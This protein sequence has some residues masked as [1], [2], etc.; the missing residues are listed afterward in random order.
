MAQ[1]DNMAEADIIRGVVKPGTSITK[2][3][4]VTDCPFCRMLQ[5]R[6][7]LTT[8]TFSITWPS[9]GVQ[10]YI[11]TTGPPIFARVRR[12]SPKK[13]AIAKQE[14]A[15]MEEMGIIQRSKLAWSSPLHMVDKKTVV[16]GRAAISDA[17][18]Q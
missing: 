1:S 3:A 14:F 8:P 15:E 9:H 10:L 18:T 7:A 6:P 16:S 4:V 2:V 17:L 13:L 12:L 11:E 5:E